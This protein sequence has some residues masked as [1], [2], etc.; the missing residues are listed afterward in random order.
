[1]DPKLA[2]WSAALVNLSVIVTLVGVGI[3]N[4]GSVGSQFT[5]VA[6]RPQHSWWR[7]F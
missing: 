2:F 3:V 4:F 7:G 1:M 5:A 6:R